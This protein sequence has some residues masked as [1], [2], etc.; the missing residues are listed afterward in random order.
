MGLKCTNAFLEVRIILLVT[1]SL[2]IA[3][4]GYGRCAIGKVLYGR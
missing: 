1:L 3:A 2:L 4:P